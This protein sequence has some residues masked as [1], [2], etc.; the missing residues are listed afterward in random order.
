M[1]E[2]VAGHIVVLVFANVVDHKINGFHL[3]VLECIINRCI[4]KVARLVVFL[5]NFSPVNNW[6]EW[7]EIFL[8]VIS[9]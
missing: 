6:I 3:V 9:K 8:I 7:V 2:Q 4:V 1:S 5:L